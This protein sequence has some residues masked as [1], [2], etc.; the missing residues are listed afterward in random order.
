[1]GYQHMPANTQPQATYAKYAT[2]SGFKNPEF[3]PYNTQK[4]IPTNSQRTYCTQEVEGYKSLL[5][6]C[7]DCFSKLLRLHCKLCVT[8]CRQLAV[9]LQADD[10]DSLLK[11]GVGLM[12]AAGTQSNTQCL[13]LATSSFNSWS[14]FM[15]A[16]GS[17]ADPQS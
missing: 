12:A 10:H 13:T 1:M 16:C 8:A 3:A 2:V 5:Q 9:V 7:C 14:V 15:A 4:R 17:A 6:V 11:A